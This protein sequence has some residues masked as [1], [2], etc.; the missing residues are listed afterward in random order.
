MSEDAI[1]QCERCHRPLK[2]NPGGNR[3]ARPIRYSHS[4]KGYCLNCAVT[5]FLMDTEPLG[6]LLE[7]GGPEML[8][9]EHVREQFGR[10]LEAGA[11]DANLDEVDWD[12]VVAMWDLPFPGRPD[13]GGRRKRRA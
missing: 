2:I 3:D 13:G 6:M 8:R 4:G 5:Q 1:V 10:I 11:C 12:L 9:L 7:R